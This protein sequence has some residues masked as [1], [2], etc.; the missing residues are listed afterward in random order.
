M[1]MGEMEEDKHVDKHAKK[2]YKHKPYECD[3]GGNKNDTD[4]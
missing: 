2:H 1:Y 4:K 3:M